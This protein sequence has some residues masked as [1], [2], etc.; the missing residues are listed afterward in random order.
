MQT[1]PQCLLRHKKNEI[2][3]QLTTTIANIEYDDIRRTCSGRIFSV[4]S[5]RATKPNTLQLKIL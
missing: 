2:K 1:E 3:I 5:I 4:Q